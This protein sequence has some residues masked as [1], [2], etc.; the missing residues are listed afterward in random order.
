MLLIEKKVPKSAADKAVT[1]NSFTL[2][3]IS[4]WLVK[5]VSQDNE[6]EIFS[7]QTKKKKTKRA[8]RFNEGA[9]N[10]KSYIHC[11]YKCLVPPLFKIPKEPSLVQ[12]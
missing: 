11:R 1:K 8:F 3:L 4:I 5:N 6:H 10:D 12:K 7:M 2:N 9:K